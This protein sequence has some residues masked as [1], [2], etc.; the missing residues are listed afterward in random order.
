M[1]DST[2]IDPGAG[3][4]GRAGELARI[5]GCLGAG[6]HALV[7][8]GGRGLGKSRLLAV[9]AQRARAEGRHRVVTVDAPPGPPLDAPALIRRLLLALRH[10]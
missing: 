3:L 7:L 5:T 2:L 6:Q 10:D 8:T 1:P 4:I 9:A